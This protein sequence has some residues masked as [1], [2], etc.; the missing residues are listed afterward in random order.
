[1]SK[2]IKRFRQSKL[3]VIILVTILVVIFF[4]GDGF[5][6]L[7]RVAAGEAERQVAFLQKFSCGDNLVVNAVPAAGVCRFFKPFEGNRRDEVAD[8][9]D[10]VSE[11]RVEQGAVGEGQEHAVVVFF[12][13]L[14]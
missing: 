13:K 6:V 11:V 7:S 10:F 1:M 3:S 9:F 5:E 14:D 4:G 2:V 12:A 8:A